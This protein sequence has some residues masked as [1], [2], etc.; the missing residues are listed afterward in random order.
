VFSLLFFVTIG[1]PGEDNVNTGDE[2]KMGDRILCILAV[3]EK[4][5]R[6]DSCAETLTFVDESRLERIR[7]QD[8]R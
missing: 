7:H 4:S 1:D 8:Q 5:N 6:G 2:G 3:E